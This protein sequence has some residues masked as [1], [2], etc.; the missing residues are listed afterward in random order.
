MNVDPS[1]HTVIV[2][3]DSDPGSMASIMRHAAA[4]LETFAT[5]DGFLGGALQVSADGRRLVQYL[6]WRDEAA[7]VA[8]RDDAAWDDLESTRRFMGLVS[9]GRAAVDERAYDVIATT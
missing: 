2:T 1:A 8:C 3:V 9:V 4:G 7:Y 5:Y 6:Q